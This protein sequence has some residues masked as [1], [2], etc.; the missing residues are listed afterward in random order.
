MAARSRKEQ[1]RAP[2][3]PP[4]QKESAAQSKQKTAQTAASQPISRGRLWLFRLVSAVFVPLLLFGL[5]EVV[6]RI[7]GYGFPPAAI[8]KCE[9]NGTECYRDNVKFA[10]QF[11]PPNI[12]RQFGPFVFP[13]DKADGTYRIFILGGSA[14]H[15]T[16]QPEYGFGRILRVLLEERY[17]GT[18]FEIIRTAMPA[19]NSH[20]VLQIAKDCAR[21]DPDLF[22]L[23]VGNNEVVGPYGAGTVFSSI[24]GNLSL[25]RAA[26]ALKGARLGQ[27]LV[28][29]LAMI[30]ADND[31]PDVWRG[32]E[33]FLEKQVRFDDTSLQYVYRH[34]QENLK[35]IIHVGHKAGAKII[36][37]TVGSNLKDCPPFASLH[38][39]NIAEAKESK[40]D[41]IYKRGVQYEEARQYREAIEKFL[42]ADAIDDRY[43]D[44][45][46]RLGRCYWAVGEYKEA[47]KRYVNAREL[48]T[49]RFR[50]DKRINAI[51]RDVTTGGKTKSVWLA[52]A[53]ETFE[54]NSPH[55]TPGEE[56]FLEHV[57]LNFK[58]NYLLA[59]TVFDKV[60][61]IL[62]EEI[63]R[64]KAGDRLPLSEDQCARRL[65]YTDW[66]R[67]KIAMAIHN[68][69][70]NAPYSNQLYH[71][72][73]FSRAAQNIQAQ[74]TGFTTSA[75][76]NIADEYRSAIKRNPGD[77]LLHWQFAV[78]LQEGLKDYAG[79]VEQY[80][81]L[82]EHSNYAAAHTNIGGLLHELGH[83][84]KGIAHCQE[85]IRIKPT[86]ADAHFKVAGM[87]ESRGQ[88]Q[89]ALDHYDTTLRLRPNYLNAHSGLIRIFVR[90]QRIDDAV[91][92]Y[93]KTLP[94]M[95]TPAHKA[96]VH[97]KIADLLLKH[98]RP[99]E[100]IAELNT[101]LRADPNSA[102]ARQRM[103]ALQKGLR[104]QN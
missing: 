28:N 16:P 69:S 2:K 17:P 62:P 59:K 37:C 10:W 38:D 77:W 93:R 74:K 33:M 31:R 34:F 98:G 39:N 27:L 4:P 23:Y 9:V 25:I 12:A 54:K 103:E 101:A 22:V 35:D 102:Q 8:I 64:K 6:L 7:V 66:D 13:L 19:I 53:V 94:Y 47:R 72:Q 63:K 55:Q 40:W 80:G 26:I 29:I 5:I 1:R 24:S 100:A 76:Q 3:S 58:G 60:E 50:A 41:E 14:A 56:L 30:S 46:F 68:A 84:D 61:E 73:R 99:E 48:D 67:Y 86:F 15:G 51:I 65:A 78:M 95:K 43:A 88:I 83:T 21:H 75:L 82:L 97:C 91:K 32:L 85:A 70:K 90:Q 42:A 81:L 18:K 57:H 104:G 52:D 71:E 49:L 20:V 11:F 79:A 87:Y 96:G 92:L 36:V 45:Q 89:K 44:L